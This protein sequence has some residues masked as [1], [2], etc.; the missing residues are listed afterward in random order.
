MRPAR[1]SEDE[2]TS[3]LAALPGWTRVE[4]R[5]AIMKRFTCADF[6]A[7]WGCMSRVA[8]I[9]ERMDHHPEWSNVWNK[10]DIT[11]STHDAGGV[12]ELDFKL[13]AEIER[14]FGQASASRT[15]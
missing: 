9:A 11:L 13:A 2:I 8:L 3:R 15:A 1:A 14:I 6:S 7:A 10:V 5:S 4:G 12:S